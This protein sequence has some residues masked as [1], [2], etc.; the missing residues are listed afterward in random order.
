MLNPGIEGLQ[1]ILVRYEDTAAA[2]GSGTVEVFATP[3]M[4]A[5]MEK[6]AMDSVA[7]FLP[8]GSITVGTQVTVSHLKATV[9]GAKV[10]CK[11]VLTSAEGRKLVFDVMAED[12][13]GLIGSGNHTRYIV[14]KQRFMD[15]I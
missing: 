2:Y 10:I 11:S 8:A 9:M 15:N 1:T 4:I 14:D 12:E 7:S 3:A 6:T 13:K 5:L